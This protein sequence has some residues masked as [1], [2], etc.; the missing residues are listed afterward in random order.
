MNNR[1]ILSIA[2]P[3]LL[4]TLLVVMSLA[5]TVGAA[6]I[7][8]QDVWLIVFAELPYIHQW[9]EPS[10]SDSTETIVLDIRMPRVIL[11]AIVGA[12]LALAGAIY[13]G[14]LRNP[15]A[16]PFILGVSSGASFGAALVF[17]FG[18]QVVW[19]GKFTLPV[20]AFMFGFGTLMVVYFLARIGQKVRMETIILAGVVVQAFIGACLSLV[21]ALA[22]EQ[23][24]TIVFWMMGSLTLTD[25]SYNQIVLPI[26]LIC[27]IIALFYAREL[28]MLG[29]GEEV[30]HHSG[31][32][33]EKTRFY[34]LILASIMTGAAVSVSGA[35]GFVGLVVPHIIRLIVGADYRLILPLS[36]F[37]GAIFL[38]GADTLARV[39]MAPRE[40]PL[41]IITAFLGAPFF[42]YLLR[43]TKREYF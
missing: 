34:L 15:L 2:I 8:W 7:N 20:V 25:W 12:A 31:V 37:G 27:S 1:L 17:A 6:N 32:S 38:V 26:I 23:L 11:A 24:Q 30:A 5:I 9:I 18:F 41:G 13:Q 42:A 16:D 14:V 33:V 40:L 35:I 36:I 3:A 10:W 43:R 29:L 21:M 39:L 22:N 19:L 4:T 28:N